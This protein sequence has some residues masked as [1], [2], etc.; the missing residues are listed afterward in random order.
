MLEATW[1]DD[2]VVVVDIHT[3]KGGRNVVIAFTFPKMKRSVKYK[4][5]PK[6]IGEN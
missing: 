5:N 6:N 4:L 2:A 3:K 1:L